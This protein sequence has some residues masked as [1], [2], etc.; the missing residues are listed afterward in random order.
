MDR[1]QIKALIAAVKEGADNSEIVDQILEINGADIENAKKKAGVETLEA[2][3]A[4]LRRQLDDYE[5][6]DG[7]KYIDPKEHER[8]K[9]FETDT[10]A[11]QKKKA[12]E[13]AVKEMLTRH[14]VKADM[15]KLVIKGLNADE[16]KLGD[17]GKVT[18]EYED[19]YMSAFKKD[20]PDSFETAQP[21]TGNPAHGGGSDGHGGGGSGDPDGFSDL[22]A[23][24]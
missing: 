12:V 4:E 2:E 17:D 1:K 8:L 20:Y 7:K 9:K 24:N 16:V 15:A 14:K 19:S 21:G 18:K 6:K 10:K 3:K 11:A 23:I 13:D 22:R 5:K